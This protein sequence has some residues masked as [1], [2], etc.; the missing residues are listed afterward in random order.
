MSKEGNLGLKP[1]DK[2]RRWLTETVPYDLLYPGTWSYSV[3]LIKFTNHGCKLTVQEVTGKAWKVSNA[4]FSSSYFVIECVAG[5]WKHFPVWLAP[6]HFRICSIERGQSEDA[7]T[8]FVS[9]EWSN[10]RYVAPEIMRIDMR[11]WRL[12][13]WKYCEYTLCA[14]PITL[15]KLPKTRVTGLSGNSGISHTERKKENDSFQT[16][17]LPNIR[18]IKN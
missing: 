3:Q 11:K 9:V 8:W 4:P 1:T 15:A 6:L 14:L 5:S 16:N 7:C 2:Y 13:D 12:C 10:L 17:I 18:L